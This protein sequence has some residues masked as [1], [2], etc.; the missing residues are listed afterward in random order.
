VLGKGRERTKEKDT[1]FGSESGGFLDGAEELR[2]FGPLCV[3]DFLVVEEADRGTAPYEPMPVMLNVPIVQLVQSINPPRPYP[4]LF[5]SLADD[6]NCIH[7]ARDGSAYLSSRNRVLQQ[8]EVRKLSESAQ[9]IQIRQ[10]GEVVGRQDQRREIRD[11]LG[12]RGL[13]ARDAVAGE[14]EGAQARREREVGELCDVVVGEVDGIL[15]LF[16]SV[17]IVSVICLVSQ[18]RV[19][20]RRARGAAGEV[21]R[22][23]STLATPRFSMAGIL[24]PAVRP[25]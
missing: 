13:D 7:A 19:E 23:K 25:F 17:R 5:P 16:T 12:E 1:D 8:H 21:G 18:S 4:P 9:Q 2:R 3:F 14:Q 11:R 6:G 20:H 24:C 22:G 10:L 15:V